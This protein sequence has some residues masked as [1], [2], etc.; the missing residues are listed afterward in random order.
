MPIPTEVGWGPGQGRDPQS[1]CTGSSSSRLCG[2]DTGPARKRLPVTSRPNPSTARGAT[3][4]PT[5]LSFR[6]LSAGIITPRQVLVLERHRG[7][8]GCA[9]RGHTA[10]QRRSKTR[11]LPESCDPEKQTS[12]C[13]TDSVLLCG[14]LGMMGPAEREPRTPQPRQSRPLSPGTPGIHRTKPPRSG[15][16]GPRPAGIANAAPHTP[17]YRNPHTLMPWL[18][19]EQRGAVVGVGHS[20]HLLPPAPG[21]P[22]P[23][24]QA[25]RQDSDGGHGQ[26]TRPSTCVFHSIVPRPYRMGSFAVPTLQMRTL[27]IKEMTRPA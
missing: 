1:F 3:P 23:T 7:Q 6:G 25:G 11:P 2:Q 18:W 5:W 17:C 9:A 21:F 24:D 8:R 19:E 15:R 13:H 10:S 20:R 16:P 14:G 12:L 22:G 4:L 27:R 26:G